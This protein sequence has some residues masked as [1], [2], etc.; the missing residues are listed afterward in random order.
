MLRPP[1]KD[2]HEFKPLLAEIE[3][4]PV[5]PLGRTTFWLVI[6]IMA[7]FVAWSIFGQ[8]DVV[9]SARGKVI[10]DGHVKILQPLDTGV[11][12]QI[13]VKEGDYV[14]KGQVVMEIDPSTVEPEV[15]SAAENLNY[16]RLEMKRIA[17]TLQASGLS[18]QRVSMLPIA[19]VARHNLPGSP[20]GRGTPSSA[21]FY[22]PAAV[23]AQR[24]L[25]LAATANLTKQL[26][27]KQAQLDQIDEQAKSARVEQQEN[28]QLLEVSLG[29]ERRLNSVRDIIAKDDYEKVTSDILTYRDKVDQAKLKLSELEHQKRQITTEMEQIKHEFARTNLQELADKHKASTELQAKLKLTSFKSAKQQ[30]VAPVDGYVDTLFLHTVGGVVT[31]A[32]KLLS[33]VPVR[34]PLV[35]KAS[36]LN[37]DIG[38]VDG[39]MPVNIKADTFDF[40]KY[41]MYE[42]KVKLVAR[43]SHEDEK[44]GLVYDVYVTPTAKSLTVDGKN[45]PLASGMGVTAE[46]KTGKRHII[47]FFIYPL[48]KYWH[49][50]MSVR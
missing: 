1:V 29:K 31:P 23:A 28:Q 27:A 47:E 13:L 18:Q 2:A 3:E 11:V 39:G 33:I 32:E 10:P 15:E 38:F 21:S 4:S 12:R 42:G 7:F 30:I 17:A 25:Y 48:I 45:E 37:K 44:Q 41:G 9:I 50:G 40:Q 16:A 8:V 43:D 35:V 46:I 36:V 19:E 22:D 6:A 49:E 24:S 26:E 5:S 34:T 20:S 14:K